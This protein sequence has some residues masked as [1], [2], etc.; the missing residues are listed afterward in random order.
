MQK[1]NACV[2]ACIEFAQI[3]SLNFFSS[4]C[5]FYAYIDANVE[6]AQIFFLHDCAYCAKF[7]ADLEICAWNNHYFAPYISAFR[8][9]GRCSI[10]CCTFRSWARLFLLRAAGLLPLFAVRSNFAM[11]QGGGISGGDGG[12]PV[13]PL[14]DGAGPGFVPRPG[15]HSFLRWSVSEASMNGWLHVS[16]VPRRGWCS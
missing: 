10:L 9:L 1:F 6:F 8:R 16:A 5:N 4:N 14:A 7:G 3:I 12:R 13:S 15:G 2:D 11:H